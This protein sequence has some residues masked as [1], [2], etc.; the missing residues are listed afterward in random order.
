M[1]VNKG[2]FNMNGNLRQIKR[3]IN[4]QRFE[5][6]KVEKNVA[7]EDSS[8][9]L[10]HESCNYSVFSLAAAAGAVLAFAGILIYALIV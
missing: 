8:M 4:S 2:D 9:P 10:V 1:L 6:I 5:N 3:G 7:V